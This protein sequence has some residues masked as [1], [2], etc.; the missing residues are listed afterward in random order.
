MKVSVTN[1][2]KKL[3]KKMGNF[4][5]E[6]ENIK[7]FSKEILELKNEITEIK[8]STEVLAANLT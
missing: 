4:N 2:L 7:K 1:I 5:R 6:L 3:D 8:I